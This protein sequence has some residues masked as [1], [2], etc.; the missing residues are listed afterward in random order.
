MGASD[1]LARVAECAGLG[2]GTDVAAIVYALARSP[3][4]LGV[5]ELSS[6]VGLSRAR[7]RTLLR[8]LWLAGLVNVGRLKGG[9]GRPRHVYTLDA[10]GLRKLVAG[11]R[12]SVE[13]AEKV[14]NGL[15]TKN[16]QPAQ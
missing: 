9:S 10:D 3:A 2:H 13:A 16:M 15:K 12:S 11:C 4:G 6:A 5:A 14:V 7:L 1:P 8:E